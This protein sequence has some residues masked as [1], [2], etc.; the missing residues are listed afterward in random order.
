MSYG[1]KIKQLNI[2]THD[3]H[4]CHTEISD[5]FLLFSVF[6]IVHANQNVLINI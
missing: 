4:A 2:N 1:S 3:S 5:I 6:E